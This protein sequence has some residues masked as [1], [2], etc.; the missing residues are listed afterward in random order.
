MTP[1]AAPFHPGGII[2]PETT[3]P[4]DL[5]YTWVDGNDPQLQADLRRYAR[6]EEDLNPERTRDLYDLLRYGLRSVERFAPWVRRVFIVTARPQAPGWL[7]TANPRVRIV[8]HDELEGFAPYLPTFNSTVIESFLHTIPGLADHYL[9][10][11]DD[12]L[13]GRAV[14]P[15]DFLAADG[16]HL[17]YGTHFGIWLPFRI[18]R[19]RW[20]IFSTVHLEHVPRF[21]YKP[22]FEEMLAA[23]PRRLHRTRTSRFRRGSDLRMDRLYRMWMLGPRRRHARAVR[24][25]DLLRIHRFH[26]I[27]NDPRAQAEALAELEAMRPKFYC[28]NDDQGPEPDAGVGVLVRDFLRRYY[29]EPSSFERGS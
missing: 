8:H 22:F 26:R 7:D 1:R 5:V 25:K 9:Y 4:I 11:N 6:S 27:E 15:E 21:V 10:L 20:K 2:T 13:F 3:P 29:P 17:V 23:Y 14:T 19:K 18:Y 24:G 16:R 28:L 12:F